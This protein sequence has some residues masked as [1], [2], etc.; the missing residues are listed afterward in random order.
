MRKKYPYLQNAYYE[1]INAGN[2]RRSFLTKIDDIFNQKQYVK[3]TLLNW[4]E[5]PIKEIQG[6][7]TSG[8]LT[9]DGSSSVRRTCQL[10]TT[11]NSGEYDLDNSEMDFAINK[12][13][14]IERGRK[15][16]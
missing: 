4:H 2:Q 7:L 1:N 12:K 10:S 8:T 15:V 14:F 13:I 3:I 16:N 11:V 9:K 5:Q 6:T